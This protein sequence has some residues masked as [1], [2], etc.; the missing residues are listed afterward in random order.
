MPG[1]GPLL[2]PVPCS[3]R[4]HLVSALHRCRVPR[5]AHRQAPH[6]SCIGTHGALTVLVP[7]KHPRYRLRT[8]G[9]DRQASLPGGPEAT[10]A[11]ARR[12]RA[13]ALPFPTLPA[14]PRTWCRLSTTHTV[15]YVTAPSTRKRG[16]RVPC[17]ARL[18]AMWQEGVFAN[19]S[20][21][22]AP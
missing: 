17:R 12:A 9:W 15:P 8:R 3:R 2:Y 7:G 18:Q 20:A 1:L 14:P 10:H 5:S 21:W 13:R 19:A 4:R 22:L 6:A 11:R 16:E